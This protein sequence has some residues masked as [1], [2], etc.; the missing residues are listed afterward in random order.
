[1]TRANLR[2]AEV[3]GVHSDAR[4]DTPSLSLSTNLPEPNLALI[5]RNR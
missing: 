1:M 5:I 2:M 3:D 4:Y